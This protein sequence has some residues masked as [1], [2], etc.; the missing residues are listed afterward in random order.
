MRACHRW[1]HVSVTLM[2]DDGRMTCA[3]DM[4]KAWRR[5]RMN[6]HDRRAHDTDKGDGYCSWCATDFGSPRELQ[7]HIRRIHVV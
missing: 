6:A 2:P 7:R 1:G 3:C 5:D 4:C